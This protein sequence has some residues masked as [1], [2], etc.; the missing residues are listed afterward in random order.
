MTIEGASR[1][2]QIAGLAE[3]FKSGVKGKFQP[4]WMGHLTASHRTR[5]EAS[6][7]PQSLV[8]GPVF[9]IP[10]QELLREIGKVIPFVLALVI[11]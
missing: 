1:A 8:L 5:V 2:R 7:V 3:A 9:G 11:G 10:F 6:G 4:P